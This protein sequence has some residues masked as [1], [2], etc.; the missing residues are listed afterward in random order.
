MAPQHIGFIGLGVMGTPMA[1]PLAQAGHHLWLHDAH[2]D[3]AMDLANAIGA[4]RV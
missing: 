3:V 4:S 2:A 1:T